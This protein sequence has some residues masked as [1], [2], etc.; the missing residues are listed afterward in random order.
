MKGGLPLENLDSPF[1]AVVVNVLV[2]LVKSHPLKFF[3]VCDALF[4]SYL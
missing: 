3:Y 1:H 2:V 4:W